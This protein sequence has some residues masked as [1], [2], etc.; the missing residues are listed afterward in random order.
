MVCSESGSVV[1]HLEQVVQCAYSHVWRF[2]SEMFVFNPPQAISRL[3]VQRV[4]SISPLQTCEVQA[5]GVRVPSPSNMRS[6]PHKRLVALLTYVGKDIPN[7]CSLFFSFYTGYHQLATRDIFVVQSHHYPVGSLDDC[8]QRHR[9]TILRSVSN[10]QPF[11][12]RT[13][14][15]RLQETQH[16]LLQRYIY[17]LIADL[18]EFFLPDPAQFAN[19]PD[20]LSKRN[21][22]LARRSTS[23]RSFS[24]PAGPFVAPVGY[25]IMPQSRTE[26]S[27]NWSRP[28]LQQRTRWARLCGMAAWSECSLISAPGRLFC[29][30]RAR[31]VARSSSALPGSG[32]PTERLA[33]ASGARASHHQRR[34]AYC[35]AFGPLGMDKPVLT[36]VPLR[37]TFGTHSAVALS[38][39]GAGHKAFSC[40]TMHSDEQLF[41]LHLK[42]I[43]LTAWQHGQK[44]P[45]LQGPISPPAAPRPSP[46]A[47]AGFY[48]QGE[49]PA[50]ARPSPNSGARASR[51]Q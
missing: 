19:L 24:F 39:G 10:D 22:A 31:L 16:E 17:V 15:T 48:A 34:L 49:R 11:R 47:L 46:V 30:L 35:T 20:Y 1:Y 21:R 38:P 42:C 18:D 51:L 23:T 41:N 5:S 12:E 8:L 27:F 50:P 44:G 14:V 43:D 9:P 28:V 37:Y 33:T 36:S 7:M 45:I 29:F 4:V 2:T 6:A 26:A 40:H 3:S 13:K 32:R 25:E